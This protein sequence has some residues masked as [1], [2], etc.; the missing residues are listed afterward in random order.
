MPEFNIS[1]EEQGRDPS[2]A[3]GDKAS[4]MASSLSGGMLSFTL[5]P[6]GGV[7]VQMDFRGESLE[8]SLTPGLARMLCGVI[9]REA[10]K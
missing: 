7:T 9:S 6:C 4:R 1:S 8:V 5:S 3:A 10:L 2:G